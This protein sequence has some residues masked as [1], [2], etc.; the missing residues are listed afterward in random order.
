MCV[1]NVNVLRTCLLLLSF[2][3]GARVLGDDIVRK[4][5]GVEITV[6]HGLPNLLQ[7][8][9]KKQGAHIIVVTNKEVLCSVF[10]R[11]AYRDVDEFSTALGKAGLH[12]S[13]IM[14]HVV[15]DVNPTEIGLSQWDESRRYAIST[16]SSAIV[17]NKVRLNLHN[18]SLS[19]L[20]ESWTRIAHGR[21]DFR[22]TIYGQTQVVI[23]DAGS[24][25]NSRDYESVLLI[26]AALSKVK[27]AGTA[28]ESN[29]RYWI[30]VAP[31]EFQS[32]RGQP[33]K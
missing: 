19:D 4:E 15:S 21:S 27:A 16:L 24:S 26:L 11:N 8:L 13:M 12:L 32:D 30:T 31:E 20:A 22:E 18:N 29:V 10:M 3:L 33:P 25:V 28:H 9:A 17:T 14:P 23:G 7:R 1:C 2:Q 5:T 6:R